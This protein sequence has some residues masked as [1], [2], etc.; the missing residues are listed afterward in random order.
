MNNPK[1]DGLPVNTILILILILVVVLLVVLVTCQ[2]QKDERTGS[3]T[4]APSNHTIDTAALTGLQVPAIKK[5]DEIVQHTGYTLC[6]RDANRQAAWV[7]YVATSAHEQ[8]QHVNRNNQFEPDPLLRTQLAGNEDYEGSGY[9]RGHL[10]PA[11]DMGWSGKTMSE[12]FYYSNMSPQLPAFNRGVWKRLE[13]LVRYW[14]TIYD[15]IYV[16]TGPVLT[17]GLPSIGPDHVS[18]PAWFYKV[19][20]VYNAKGARAVGFL[21]PNQASAATL[22]KFALPVDSIEQHTGLDFFPRLP[23]DVENDIESKVDAGAWKWTRN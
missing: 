21:L 22:R 6:Y 18:V 15:S 2:R 14:S 17:P 11:E 3:P 9:D 10:A 7:A 16:V 23:D 5:D 20:L 12:S 1:R 13:E 19:V 8:A 4:A